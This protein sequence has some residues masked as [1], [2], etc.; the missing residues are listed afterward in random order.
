[1]CDKDINEIK[2]RRVVEALCFHI[3][4]TFMYNLISCID[5]N[6]SSHIKNIIYTLIYIIITTWSIVIN[7]MLLLWILVTV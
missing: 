3:I 2:N 7:G 5:I 1:M 6:K 4:H